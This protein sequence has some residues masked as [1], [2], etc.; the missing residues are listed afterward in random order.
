LFGAAGV[1]AGAVFDTL[2]LMNDPSFA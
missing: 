2:E 1:P